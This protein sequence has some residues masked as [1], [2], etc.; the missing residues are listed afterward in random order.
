MFTVNDSDVRTTLDVLVTSWVRMYT[1]RRGG[2]AFL[3]RLHARVSTHVALA[4]VPCVVERRGQRGGRD[5]GWEG[6]E[7]DKRG[8]EG[9]RAKL[10]TSPLYH[11]RRCVKYH[12]LRQRAGTRSSSVTEYVRRSVRGRL[13][14]L[15]WPPFKSPS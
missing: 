2:R 7:A 10:Y 3:A 5:G 4:R 14:P 15:S 11:S 9:K 12:A 8:E 13:S 1:T 6:K